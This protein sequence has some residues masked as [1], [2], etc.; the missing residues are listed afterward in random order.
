MSDRQRYQ[1]ERWKLLIADR[2]QSKLKLMDWCESQ[3]ITKDAY[4]Y[5]LHKLQRENI[6][7]ALESLPVQIQQSAAFVEIPKPEKCQLSESVR[8]IVEPPARPAAIIK[9]N[10]LQIELFSNVSS[11]MLQEILR[12]VSNV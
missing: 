10:Q 12:V 6:D 9:N 8:V 11:E 3:G 7:T 1:I 2:A 4:Y 5:W